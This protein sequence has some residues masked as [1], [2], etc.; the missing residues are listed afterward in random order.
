MSMP[1]RFLL[2]AI[3]LVVSGILPVMTNG[4]SC[5]DLPCCDHSGRLVIQVSSSECCT[6]SNCARQLEAVK[7]G[8][9][10]FHQPSKALFAVALPAPLTSSAT[11]Q[12]VAISPSP[13]PTAERLSKLSI[14]LI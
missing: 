4:A 6:P 10:S 1:R 13:P 5:N 8:S 7:A 2:F 12:L 9:S 11:H 14:L 3:A